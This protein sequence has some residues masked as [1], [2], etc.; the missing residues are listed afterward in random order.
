M[1][2][3]GRL[4]EEIRYISQERFAS[5]KERFGIP[6]KGD[7][8][9]TAVGTLGNVYVV[10]FDEH[11]YF[12]DGN[13]IWIRNLKDAESDFLGVQLRSAKATILEGAIGTS[14]KA[15][16]IA[17]LQNLRI[18]FPSLAEQRAIAEALSD[19][20]GLLAALDLLIAKKRDLKQ[21]AIQQLLTA[22]TRLP[23]FHGEWEVKQLGDL[24]SFTGGYSASRAQLSA[25]GHLYLH[26][27]D[28][29]GSSKT[30]IDVEADFQDIPKLNVPGST[31]MMGV[32]TL[33]SVCWWA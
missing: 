4:I 23:G 6:T 30:W 26:Y 25:E 19:V 33:R 3:E 8:L 29:H 2:V 16:T 22:R 24:F 9:I 21:A 18:A 11:F 17:G 31:L 13:L 20:D 28:I 27:G 32:R 15:L 5:V 10:N 7:I 1:L 14:Q 12:K